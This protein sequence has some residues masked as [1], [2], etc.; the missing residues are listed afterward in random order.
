[1]FKFADSSI[2]EHVV[3]GKMP[4]LSSTTD[5][6]ADVCR[7]QSCAAKTR[8]HI[9][10]VKTRRMYEVYKDCLWF[11]VNRGICHELETLE[12]MVPAPARLPHAI[13]WVENAGAYR[14][15]KNIVNV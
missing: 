6:I 14:K 7:M 9:K 8:V 3:L 4:L 2:T 5:I 15:S 1:M 10:K 11:N 13:L 12:Y